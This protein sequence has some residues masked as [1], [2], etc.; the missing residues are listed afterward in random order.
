MSAFGDNVILPFHLASGEFR[1]RLVRAGRA[2]G[3][4]LAGH[5]YPPVVAAL[6]AETVVLGVA[7]SSVLKYD[8][9]FTLQ[10]QGDGP[11]RALIADV[12]SAGMV[13]AVARYDAGRLPAGEPPAAGRLAA[14]I[15]QGHLAFT[16]DQG[17]HTERYQG[18][19]QIEGDSLAAC[20]QRYFDLS[21]QLP[22]TLLVATRPPVAGDEAW[23]ATALLLQRM[24]RTAGPAADDGGTDWDDAW[25]TASVL[26]RSLTPAELTDPALTPEALLR[27]PFHAQDL[28]L[29]APRPVFYG[30]RCS[31]RK[32]ARALLTLPVEERESLAENGTI[33]VTCEFCKATYALTPSELEALCAEP[34]PGPSGEPSGS[35]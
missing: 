4:T 15:G 19:V 1:G 16:V 26:M 18:I 31:A 12:T 14:L 29:A 7:L 13:R 24:P 8:G 2:V 17:P 35:A 23:G 6:V 9:V 20:A 25:E 21:E 33:D 30:C 10:I 22:T 11:V 28:R 34:S 32:V 5:D 3:D 27:R